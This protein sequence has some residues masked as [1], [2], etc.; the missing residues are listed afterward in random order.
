MSAVYRTLADAFERMLQD[1]GGGLLEGLVDV[2]R[3]DAEMPP[4]EVKGVSD[5]FLAGKSS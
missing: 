4:R 1:N 2:L 3:A 5:E